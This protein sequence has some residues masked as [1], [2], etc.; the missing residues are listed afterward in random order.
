LQYKISETQNVALTLNRRITRPA[1]P[2]LNPII[3]VIDH[4]LHET[5]NKDLNPETAD[6]VEINHSLIKQ[7]LQLRT[8]VFFSTTQN[9]IT[10]VTL[11]SSPKNLILTYINGKR[12]NRAGTNMDANFNINKYISI[13][14]ALSLFYSKTTGHYNEIDLSANNLAWTGSFKVTV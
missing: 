9:F 7:K 13:N 8:G 14:P 6:K 2:Q 11:L 5:G 12:D 4:T 3:N 1:Y 10:Q